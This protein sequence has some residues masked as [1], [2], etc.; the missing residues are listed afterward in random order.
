MSTL[1][2]AVSACWLGIGLLAFEAQ[3]STRQAARETSVRGA[4]WLWR[5][6][7]LAALLAPVVPLSA[8]LGGALALAACL[9]ASMAAASLAVLLAPLWPRHYRASVWASAALTIVAGFL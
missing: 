6:V 8:E 1:F 7:G 5:A 3:G 2:F 4:T 9:L